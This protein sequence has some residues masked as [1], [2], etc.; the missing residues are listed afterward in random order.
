MTLEGCADHF[1][2]MS[3]QGSVDK[4]KKTKTDLDIEL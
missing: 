2:S 4:T 1:T 3:D